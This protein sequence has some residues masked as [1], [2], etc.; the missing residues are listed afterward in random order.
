MKISFVEPHLRLF[1]GI[2]RII[3][4]ANRLSAMGHEVT[5]YHSDGS[6]CEWMICK[7]GTKPAATLFRDKHDVLVYNDPNPRD[8]V[9]VQ[10]AR[11]RLKVHYTLGLY[12]KHLLIGHD[13]RLFLP[14][15]RK[16][17]ILKLMLQA[18]HLQ[19]SNA[20]WMREWLK[21]NMNVDT[22]L[23]IG[24]VNR[25]MFLPVPV[26]KNPGEIRLLSSGDPRNNKGTDLV[27]QAVQLAKQEEP[28]I[29]L[30]QYHGKALPQ[31]R[32]AQVYSSA[33]IFVDGQNSGGWNNP[34]AEAMACKVAVVCTRIGAVAD[35]A[36][37][38]ETALVVP[39]NDPEAMAAAILRLARDPNLRES[40]RE[41]AYCRISQFDWDKSAAE[42]A[43]ILESAMAG[44][45]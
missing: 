30:D 29:V 44:R 27:L 14:R 35:F 5:I 26:R 43:E 36:F 8:F 13:P 23:V 6:A 34:V 42:F 39:P 33:D 45:N 16:T 24:G 31:A 22:S 25:E 2:R 19:L 28:A 21:E 4:L 20:T 15:N 37:D 41:S 18:P 9:L 10:F 32:M 12:A 1:G 3:E 40:L 7:A 38:E 11:A 17:F